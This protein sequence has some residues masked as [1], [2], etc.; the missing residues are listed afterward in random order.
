MCKPGREFKI[1][2]LENIIG[3][4]CRYYECQ[5]GF[6]RGPLQLELEEDEDSSS[7]Y[8]D[9]DTDTSS[10]I[11]SQWSGVNSSDSFDVNDL[12]G[13]DVRY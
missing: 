7:S 5:D 13:M 11:H 12:K 1:D 3:K 8:S 10:I 6:L 2:E 4:Y 9:T